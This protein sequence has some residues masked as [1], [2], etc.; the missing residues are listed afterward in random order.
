MNILWIEDAGKSNLE[1]I[2]KDCFIMS[3]LFTNDKNKIFTVSSLDD[4]FDKVEG[5][6][7][8]YDYYVIDLD[9]TKFQIGKKGNEI[10][11]KID[12]KLDNIA[13]KKKA[14]HLFY[15]KLLENGV[16]TNRIVF[17]TGNAAGNSI[18]KWYRSLKQAINDQNED[19]Y[20]TVLAHLT[21]EPLFSDFKD[22]FVNHL[23]NN[24]I[25][26]AD[27]I[28]EIIARHYDES[29]DTT[30]G[31]LRE[32]ARKSWI[33]HYPEAFIKTD[34]EDFHSWLKDSL[35]KQNPDFAYITLRRG[36]IDGCEFLIDELEKNKKDDDFILFNKTVKFKEEYID[37]LYLIQ[38]LEKLT[39]FLPQATPEPTM[40]KVFYYRLLKELSAEW[41]RSLGRFI[42]KKKINDYEDY[43]LTF[44]QGQMKFI[45]NWASHSIMNEEIDEHFLTF[46]FMVA[47]RALFKMEI[48][49]SQDYET[50]LLS[51]FS[52]KNKPFGNL[53]ENLAKSYY[54]LRNS[55]NSLNKKIFDEKNPWSNNFQ[56]LFRFYCELWNSYADR[57]D[58]KQKSTIFL[59]QNFWHSLF[60]LTTN[61]NPNTIGS[62]SINIKFDISKKPTK[63][64]FP[65]KV[66]QLIHK[67]SFKSLK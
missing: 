8:N 46:N 30:F 40:K 61:L 26:Q 66:A 63:G 47:M 44:C 19:L 25:E 53:K 36:I 7:L 48:D 34:P 55:K 12:P 13:F 22:E 41:E 32:I 52:Y 59:Y 9:L 4:A 20:K 2:R 15:L 5:G 67:Q 38:F 35:T 37:R 39:L 64:S 57:E 60:P 56:D 42:K 3:G 16:K 49:K 45:R 29:S 27:A 65:Y 43:F 6:E 62:I 33:S 28:V 21:G 23:N 24:E 51:S 54:D 14:G 58:V 11:N 50:Q 17:L 10:K 31:K 18:R 1:N